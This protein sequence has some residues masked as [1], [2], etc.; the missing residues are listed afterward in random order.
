MNTEYIHIDTGH[1]SADTA[2]NIYLF[3]RDNR[4]VIGGC[5]FVFQLDGTAT[6]LRIKEMSKG[7]LSTFPAVVKGTHVSWGNYIGKG[8]HIPTATILRDTEDAHEM[9][10]EMLANIAR[11]TIAYRD[12]NAA[13]LGIDE[14]TATD[15]QT[16]AFIEARP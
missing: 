9:A 3:L 10:V 11:R 16:E 2:E 1:T 12:K 13:Q 7:T 8:E 14:Q 15:M 4:A 6:S 5:D